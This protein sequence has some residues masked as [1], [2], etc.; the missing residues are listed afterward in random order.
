M[1]SW[2]GCLYKTG[3]ELLL[4]VFPSCTPEVSQTTLVTHGEGEVFL[5]LFPGGL[6]TF[7]DIWS[8]AECSL[9]KIRLWVWGWGGGRTDG[10]TQGW[11]AINVTSQK[12]N[13]VQGCIAARSRVSAT[14]IA[15]LTTNILSPSRHRNVQGYIRRKTQ[16]KHRIFNTRTVIKIYPCASLPP[17]PP[18]PLPA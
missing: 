10:Q 9:V 14:W 7:A 8:K 3:R 5:F 1:V 18:P 16:H 11:V 4:S 2:Q 15:L 6:V 13:N 12:Y 17:P